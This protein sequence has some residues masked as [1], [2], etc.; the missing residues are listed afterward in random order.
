MANPSAIANDTKVYLE[1]LDLT[2]DATKADAISWADEIAKQIFPPTDVDFLKERFCIV[3]D[4]V[5]SFLSETATEVSAR[6][7]LEDDTKTVKDGS[8]WYEE[9]LPCETILYGFVSASKMGIPKNGEPNKYD[10]VE[11]NVA[12]RQIDD[13]LK[14]NKAMQFGGKATVGRGMCRLL[15]AK[16]GNANGKKETTT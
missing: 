1:D 12:M 13:L 5:M 6:I 7:K 4:D 10:Y 14:A 3:S 9:A 11:S 8:L 15:L 16:N 2:A